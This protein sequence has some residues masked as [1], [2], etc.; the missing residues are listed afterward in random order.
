MC[1]TSCCGGKPSAD[2]RQTHRRRQA[3]RHTYSPKTTST[4]SETRPGKSCPPSVL[5]GSAILPRMSFANWSE[6]ILGLSLEIFPVQ[7]VQ[8]PRGH[9][10]GPGHLRTDIP[11]HHQ[12]GDNHTM[13]APS[14]PMRTIFHRRQA[15][16]QL[17]LIGRCQNNSRATPSYQT[18]AQWSRRM[19]T[20][21]KMTRI[22][23]RMR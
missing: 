1:S 10:V 19:M 15:W 13:P 5:H 9:L 4:P 21:Q 8:L 16:R 3:H 2:D 18:R 7:T 17:A 12:V 11:G 20:A 6:G 22:R 14:A 23:M